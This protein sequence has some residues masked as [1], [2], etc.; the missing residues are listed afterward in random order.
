MA[1][2]NDMG[3]VLGNTSEI[4]GEMKV[5]KGISLNGYFNGKL[6]SGGKIL[7]GK[8]G[9]IEADIEG[10]EIIIAGHVKGN[11]IAKSKVIIHSRG[12][13]DGDVKTDSL[14]LEDGGLINGKIDMGY[15]S[16]KKKSTDK[17]EKP[18]EEKEGE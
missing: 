6:K 14:I 1:N 9:N 11:I 12:K 7:I 18:E 15:K 16:E 3:T 10:Q 2:E 17:K 8:K 5:E 13:V 4:T